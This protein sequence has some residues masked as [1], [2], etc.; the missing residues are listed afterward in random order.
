M[1][2]TKSQKM[3]AL[4]QK[5]GS[6]KG[7]IS[8]REWNLL[9]G[10][11]FSFLNGVSA[12]SVRGGGARGNI[13]TQARG[14]RVNAPTASGFAG[15]SS[16]AKITTMSSGT[17]R[18]RHSEFVKD[19]PPSFDFTVENFKINPGETE[20]F[21][22]LSTIAQ[23]FESYQF[24]NFNIRY[25]TTSPTNTGGTAIITVDYNPTANIPTSKTQALAMESAVRTPVWGSVNHRSLRHNLEKRKSYYVRKPALSVIDPDLYDVGQAMMMVE[26]VPPDSSGNV[27]EMYVDYEVDLITPVLDTDISVSDTVKF[28]SGTNPTSATDGRF[29]FEESGTEFPPGQLVVRY[30]PGLHVTTSIGSI[31]G[32]VGAIKWLRSGNY[33]VCFDIKSTIGKTLTATDFGAGRLQISPGG[34]LDFVNLTPGGEPVM[35][36]AD[37]DTQ[38][39]AMYAIRVESDGRVESPLFGI[40]T[41]ISLTPNVDAIEVTVRIADYAHD[42]N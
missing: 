30:G 32:I 15:L 10:N 40:G 25:E 20:L 19:I 42:L 22:W 35:V 1:T 2:K 9:N 38:A 12:R 8:Q 34:L 13:G 16:K 18:V 6:K 21:P 7:K 29:M 33:L 11:T 24:K 14:Q 23:R 17:T 36:S 27:G 39:F 5:K 37:D 31:G 26:G 41:D 28:I 4:T 3:R